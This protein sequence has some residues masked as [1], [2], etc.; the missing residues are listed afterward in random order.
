MKR[1]DLERYLLQNGCEFA[2][3]GK[4]HDIWRNVATGAFDSLPRHQEIDN[5][6]VRSICRRLGV[7]PPAP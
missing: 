2:R 5:R 1:G 6:L 3:N 7:P 4:R